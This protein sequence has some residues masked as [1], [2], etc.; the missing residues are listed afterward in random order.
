[1]PKRKKKLLTKMPTIETFLQSLD[2]KRSH[3]ERLRIIRNY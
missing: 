1:M 2:V 3:V